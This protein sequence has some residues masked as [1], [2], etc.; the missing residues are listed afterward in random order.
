MKKKDDIVSKESGFLDED[1]V[2]ASRTSMSS[3]T[4]SSGGDDSFNVNDISASE[5]KQVLVSKLIM[6]VVLLCAAF[7]VGYATWAFTS[8]TEQE[9]FESS[10]EGF[11]NEIIQVS[12]IN[13]NAE[14]Q[15]LKAL[16]LSV[17]AYSLGAASGEWPFVTIMP[18][19]YWEGHNTMAQMGASWIILTPIVTEDN[20]ETYEQYVIDNQGWRNETWEQI[21]RIG[22]PPGPVA[23]CIFRYNYTDWS[24]KCDNGTADF[25]FDPELPFYAPVHGV[26]VPLDNGLPGGYT[27]NNAWADPII[28]PIAK[29]MMRTGEGV[30]SEAFGSSVYGQEFSGDVMPDSYLAM[31]VY[32]SFHEGENVTIVSF[33]TAAITW[34]FF[35][36]ILSDEGT[37]GI[38]LYLENKCGS[39]FTFRIDG[40]NVTFVGPGD[41]HDPHYD[42]LE[43]SVN[44]TDLRTPAQCR[45][46]MN[47]YP[48]QEF[49]DQY[50]TN[51]PAVFTVGA[52]MIFV[53]T[54]LFFFLYDC[55][56]K[57]RQNV[58]V[59]SANRTGAL[60]NSMYPKDVRERL[61]AD[62]RDNAGHESKMFGLP[63]VGNHSNS[64]TA[65]TMSSS[66]N[67]V[68]FYNT[69]P[70]ADYY[71][72][73]SLMVADLVGFTAWSSEREPAQ[74]F[75]LL[76][77][78]YGEF[79]RIGKRRKIFKVETF[80]DC[81]VAAAGYP[82]PMENHAVTICRF[83]NE[84]R[85]ETT[86]IV[87]K[88]EVYLG[89]DTG[90]LKLRVGISSGPITG[91]VLR[92]SK[93]RFQLFGETYDNT[94]AVRNQSQAGRIHISQATADI[95]KAKGRTKWLVP[96]EK[97]VVFQDNITSKTYW[98]KIRQAGKTFTNDTAVD[99][100]DQASVTSDADHELDVIE[101]SMNNNKKKR[102]VDWIVDSLTRSLKMIVAMRDQN[103]R[104][105][106][107]SSVVPSLNP[108]DELAEI[109]TLS[110]DKNDFKCDPSTV[111]LPPAVLKQ[112]QKY[113]SAIGDLYHENDF[114]NFE[115]A[116]HVAQAIT[117]LLSRVVSTHTIDTTTMAY[118][119]KGEASDLHDNTF[120]L[121]SD[122][123]I[124][125]ACVYS[126]L[127]HDADHPGV[128]NAVLVKEGSELAEF[129]NQK[130]VAEQNS[131]DLSWNMLMQ[132]EYKDLRKCIYTNQAELERFRQLVV[133][134]VMATDIVDKEQSAFRKGR[135][136][137]AFSSEDGEDETEKEMTDRKA[138]I[139]IEH[140]IQA[141]DVSHMMQ[142]WEVYIKW[143][144]KFFRE[145]YM[146]YLDGRQDSDPSQGWYKGEMGF[147]DFYVIPLAKKLETCGVFGVSSDE[148]LNYAKAN[149]KKWELEGEQIVERYLA[150]FRAD[151]PPP[152]SACTTAQQDLFR[153]E[154]EC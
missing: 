9:D 36:D 138:T 127:V 1:D 24:T 141:A 23:E 73:G 80:G 144:E 71:P 98:L 126:A 35:S 96:T 101:R 22:P 70:I 94:F 69:T 43:I 67:G 15:A 40:P 104:V 72:E 117:K 100:S 82:E 142:H 68:L 88:L 6:I 50:R 62:E 131:V 45:Y 51:R 109:I 136:N 135:W 86:N 93:S 76:E 125:F 84:C 4:G 8:N 37:A 78:L 12:Q 134:S 52:I 83:A 30:L 25:T 112:L 54:A 147:Y 137:K 151:H 46:V 103:K 130:S 13:A 32:D 124:H 115:H 2:E 18:S 116:C 133:N 60:V 74:V 89:P 27:Q 34:N 55:L 63:M 33:L 42:Y 122:P 110:S 19:F 17:T 97:T 152:E 14:F 57:K 44:A 113:V 56:V 64:L 21:G 105:E 41:L 132:D 121:T 123:M 49:E 66:N 87:H 145:C 75:V 139:V 47:L 148:Y 102:L 81:Y 53:I 3:N 150:N 7:G 91:G 61:L 119:Q 128:S 95:L 118:V 107:S 154:L 99:S 129:Y 108:L 5:N 39:T 146:G 58:V 85:R 59:A 48:S 11:A 38:Y 31:P 28:P 149:R 65:S 26:S 92:G 29:E 79:D 90:D 10:F 77:T 111:E 153:N 114:H 143:N 140:L 106:K 20:R 16:A 120:G